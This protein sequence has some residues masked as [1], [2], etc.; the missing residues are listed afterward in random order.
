[1]RAKSYWGENLLNRR[2][3][4]LALLFAGICAAQTNVAQQTALPEISTQETQPGVTIHARTNEVLVRVVVRDSNGNPVSNLTRDDF[5]LLDDGKPQII[6]EFSVKGSG[7]TPAEATGQPPAKK[8]AEQAQTAPSAPTAPPTRFVAIYYDDTFMSFEQIART[9]DAAERYLKASLAPG[10][11]VALFT[12]SKDPTLD[13]TSDQKQLETAMAKLSPHPLAMEESTRG[14]MIPEYV[15]Y[16]IAVQHNE[17]AIDFGT[18]KVIED[19]CG[20]PSLPSTV[21]ATANAQV[22]PCPFDPKIRAESEAQQMWDRTR[23]TVN[24]SLQGLEALV[25]RMSVMPGQRTIVWVGPGFLGMDQNNQLTAITD[26]ALRAGV[27]INSLDSRGLW[28]LIP[29]G[30]ASKPSTDRSGTRL[31]G[32]MA[33]LQDSYAQMSQEIDPA[34]LADAAAATGGVF[35][36][37]TNDFDSGFRRVG[38]LPE[39]AYLL[40]FSPRNLKFDGKY[41]NLKVELVN[42][43]GLTVQARKGYYA[44]AAAPNSGTEAQED[45]ENEVF[46]NEA[47]NDFPLGIQTQFF[48]SSETE[49]KLSVLA[50]VDLHGVQL[51][52]ENQVNVDQLKFVTALFDNNGNLMEGRTRTVTLR[53]KDATL[54]KLLASGLRTGWRF[55][56]KPGTYVVR[57][58]VLDSGSGGIAALSRTVEIPYPN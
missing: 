48:M 33:A 23:F 34:V 44:P 41:H 57:E 46:A 39:F 21:P 30:D 11:R 55:D 43:R 26:Q 4:L 3:A 22:N 20:A 56:V 13:F 45:I 2:A 19:L 50:V 54:D 49:G 15:A 17:D 31:T 1:M 16:L 12:S 40:S 52:K 58:V 14:P 25:R 35:I 47:R 51:Q 36:H 32:R 37:D 7:A 53:L 10:D 38:A 5:R 8:A 27:V 18:A 29:G 9:R 24:R 42:G 6:R 28:D